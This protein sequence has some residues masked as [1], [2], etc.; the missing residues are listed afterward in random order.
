MIIMEASMRFPLFVL[1]NT[2]LLFFASCGQSGLSVKSPPVGPDGITQNETITSD[3]SNINGIY[4]T[5]LYPVNYNLQLR[6]VGVAAVVRSGDTF[7]AFV[8]MQYGQKDTALRQAIYTGRRC[9]NINDDLNKDAYIDIQ[10]A[11]FAIGQVTIPLD[12]NLDSQLEGGSEFPIGDSVYGRYFYEIRASFE[13]M[14]SDLKTTD[15]HL[16]DDIVKLGADSGL[17]F[18]GR[19][20]VLQG[21]NE[22]V[23]LPPTAGTN[24]GETAYKTMPIACGVLWKVAK[25]PSELEGL[26]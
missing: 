26:E 5:D 7:S 22:S 6:K 18:P 23:F 9:P 24:N 1:A 4:A 11:L 3:G 8:K 13:K 21:L 17:T 20:I 2:L 12:H 15:E 16:D 10:E 25:L 19:V 14:F